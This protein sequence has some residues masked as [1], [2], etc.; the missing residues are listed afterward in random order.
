M[1]YFLVD[2]LSKVSY[3]FVSYSA[4]LFSFLSF[5]LFNYFL[6]LPSFFV[7]VLFSL[8][9]QASSLFSFT[10]KRILIFPFY[11]PLH[12]LFHPTYIHSFSLSI[13][14]FYILCVSMTASQ[15]QC[16]CVIKL[17]STHYVNELM[18][19]LWPKL[20]PSQL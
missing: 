6:F 19:S 7:P 11:P 8:I 13:F 14:S 17:S 1:A 20:S 15:N 16:F 4:S 10:P 18:V 12:S 3:M 2:A 9:L 5:F